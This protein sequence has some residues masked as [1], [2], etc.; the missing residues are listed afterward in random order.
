MVNISITTDDESSRS[1]VVILWIFGSLIT[2]A[3]ILI[4]VVLL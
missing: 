4:L 2:L 3:L 1:E